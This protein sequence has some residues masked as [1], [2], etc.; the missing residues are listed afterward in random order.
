MLNTGQSE[1]EKFDGS[2]FKK[3]QTLS[4]RACMNQR[5]NAKLKSSD[6]KK[7]QFTI[8]RNK[9]RTLHV[10]EI[11]FCILCL[12]LLI[13]IF[14]LLRRAGTSRSS[15]QRCSVKKGVLRNFAK[16]TVKRL[17][18]SLFFNKVAG[19]VLML[20]RLVFLCKINF[21]VKLVLLYEK[22]F[23]SA[24]SLETIVFSVP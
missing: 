16:F 15:Q 22:Q 18:Q 10:H 19:A 3:N 14:Y 7:A 1:V 21:K 9:Q 8:F 23:L 17:C 6:N 12:D 4:T 13:I 20:R 11:S 5:D 24:L 2:R